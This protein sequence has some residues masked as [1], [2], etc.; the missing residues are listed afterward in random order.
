[1]SG[2]K[3]NEGVMNWIRKQFKHEVKTI[4]INEDS[5]LSEV[6]ELFNRIEKRRTHR[7]AMRKIKY[8]NTSVHW[9]VK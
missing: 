1:M 2:I 8:S 6:E 9:I 3:I 5:K 4:E 7:I